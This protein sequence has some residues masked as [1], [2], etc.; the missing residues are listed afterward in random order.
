LNDLYWLP[1][2]NPD[3]KNEYAF[4]YEITGEIHQDFSRPL[5][6]K[7]IISAF[8]N[9]IRDM[10]Q[11][12]PGE[13]SYWTAQN[14]KNVNTSGIESSGSLNYKT[15]RLELGFNTNYSYTRATTVSS[16]TPEDVSVGRQLVYIPMHQAN[17]SLLAGYG[18]FYSSWNLLLNSR[19]YLNVENTSY[20][21]GYVL[22]NLLAGVK[23]KPKK[24]TL[25]FSFQIDN[26]FD[27]SYQTIA[28]YPLPGRSYSLKLLLQILK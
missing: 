27:V 3:L 2:G 8:M 26:I 22:N 10:I 23:L 21:P 17:C 14:I 28:Y 7:L 4:M 25:D 13:Y 9:N 19:R 15:G 5:A 20:L 12:M 11:W 18:R 16:G 1:G 6:M 24:L